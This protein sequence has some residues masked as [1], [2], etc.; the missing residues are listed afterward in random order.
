MTYYLVTKIEFWRDQQVSIGGRHIQ[1][2]DPVNNK[3]Y[4]GYLPVF[5]DYSAALNFVG[6][7]EKF[8]R[9]LET[10]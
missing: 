6:G 10:L 8:I 7:E 2:I 3:N 4:I 9:E 5:D 1:L